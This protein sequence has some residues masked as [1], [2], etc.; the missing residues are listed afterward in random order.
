MRIIS[1]VREPCLR[2]STR[3]MSA[4]I[5]LSSCNLKCVAEG[6]AHDKSNKALSQ[7]S[8]VETP[9]SEANRSAWVSMGRALAQSV[10]SAATCL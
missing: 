9:V 5:V 3:I 8:H 1:S 4:P 6:N 2:P 7:E 10:L